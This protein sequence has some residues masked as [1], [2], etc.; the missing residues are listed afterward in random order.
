MRPVLVLVA[1]QVRRRHAEDEITEAALASHAIV[2][3]EP[4]GP[5]YHVLANPEESRRPLAACRID[6][7]SR[8]ERAVQSRSR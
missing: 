3:E 5:S 7:D 6:T 1:P 8:A 4:E 2:V